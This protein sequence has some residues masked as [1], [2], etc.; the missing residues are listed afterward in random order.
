MDGAGIVLD[1]SPGTVATDWKLVTVADFAGDGK[2][3]IL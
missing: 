1:G 3:D 2:A